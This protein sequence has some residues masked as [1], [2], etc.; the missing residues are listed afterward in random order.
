MW[1]FKERMNGPGSDK[2][3]PNRTKTVLS[4]LELAHFERFL[5][6]AP[7]KVEVKGRKWKY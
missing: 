5:H 1:I 6:E 7:P 2:A 3:S 4:G